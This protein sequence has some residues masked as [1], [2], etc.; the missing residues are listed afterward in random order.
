MHLFRNGGWF[1]CIWY[2]AHNHH[3]PY[4]QPILFSECLYADDATLSGGLDLS[5]TRSNGTADCVHKCQAFDGCQYWVVQKTLRRG[6]D[7][8]CRL[9]GWKGKL[10]K[11]PGFV[12]GSVPEAC[13][14]SIFRSW[15]EQDGL[16]V[17]KCEVG[18][19]QRSN[20]ES[21]NMVMVVYC[22]RFYLL[23]RG[24]KLEAAIFVS[25]ARM[26]IDWWWARDKP[27]ILLMTNYI[28]WHS[29]QAWRDDTNGRE[30]WK[31][32]CWIW[33]RIL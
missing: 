15:T 4:T 6:E 29:I 23:L 18:W 30:R 3:C 7:S 17:S 11:T 32:P 21:S 8:E 28:G 31:K 13:C 1:A 26:D 24:M 16:A 14:K 22:L 20:F 12:S 33:G 2:I 25:L 5:V 10:V 27:K 9:R 19:F